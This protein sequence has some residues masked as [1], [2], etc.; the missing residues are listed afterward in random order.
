M[1]KICV[2]LLCLLLTACTYNEYDIS[3]LDDIF[4]DNT[5]NDIKANNYT[6]YIEYYLP[7]DINEDECNQLS[8]SFNIE[9]DKIIMNINISDIFNDEYYDE[10]ILTDEGFFDEDKL[11]YS[12][13]G[14]FININNEDIK[15]LFKAYGY[16]DK[17]LLYMVSGEVTIYG[18]CVKDRIVLLSNKIYQLAKGCNVHN[19]KIIADFSSKNVID[20]NKSPV[21][22]FEPLFPTDG[23]V[24][25]MMVDT[26]IEVTQE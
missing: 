3:K 16:D 1:K 9:D 23:R 7:S 14:E 19:D 25:D 21:N 22:L 6:K 24:D 18:Y 10:A 13:Q 12:K 5:S 11:I 8:Y 26:D 20:Y 15:Y 17:C 4:I 2:L